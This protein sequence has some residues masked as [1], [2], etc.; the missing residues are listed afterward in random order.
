MAS[1][2]L[3]GLEKIWLSHRHKGVSIRAGAISANECDVTP[4][5]AETYCRRAQLCPARKREAN[6]AKKEKGRQPCDRRP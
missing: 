5:H 2:D 6:D 3:V 4:K 1:A